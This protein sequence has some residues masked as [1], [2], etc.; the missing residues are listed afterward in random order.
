[1]DP[2]FSR[3]APKVGVVKLE[4]TMVSVNVASAACHKTRYGVFKM[5]NSSSVNYPL[6]QLQDF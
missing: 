6:L 1:M 5:Q 3:F 4:V 2:L